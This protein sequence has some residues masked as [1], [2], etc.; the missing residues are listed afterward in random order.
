MLRSA[1]LA[2][3][4]SA[5][6]RRIVTANPLTGPVVD[7]Y[8]AGTSAADAVA[9]TSALAARGMHT[10][11][12]H[13]GE[14][15]LDAGQAADTVNAYRAVLGS[16]GDAGLA[17]RAEVSVKLSAVGQS[18]PCLLY[19]SPSPRDRTRSRMPSSA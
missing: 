4:R 3:A 19:T 1:L 11:L 5:N 2:A 14:D 15:T 17:G 6:V 16:L 13:L 18:L 9:A 12:D 8:V 7:R 10:S